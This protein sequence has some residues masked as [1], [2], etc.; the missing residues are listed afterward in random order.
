MG[1]FISL[2]AELLHRYR[3]KTAAYDRQEALRAS[4]TRYQQLFDMITEG[5]SLE[6][7][8]FDEGGKPYD[9]RYL[10]VNPAF[11]RHTGLKAADLI[12]RTTRELFPEAE[13]MWLEFYGKVASTGEPAT[14]EAWFGSLGRCFQVS[15]FQAEP[16]VCGV[17]FFDITD[18]KIA[19]KLL[20][21]ARQEAE[22]RA[23]DAEEGKRTLDAIG[24]S[25]PDAIFVKDLEG[26]M[27]YANAGLFRAVGRTADQVLGR[28]DTEWFLNPEE[29][30]A[31]MAND[32]QVMKSR[33]TQVIEEIVTGDQ[34]IHIWLSTKSP[35]LNS[36]G[37]VSG[38]VGVARDITDRRRME[39]G[40]KEEAKRKDEFLALLG[41]ELRNPLVPITNAVYLIRKTGQD[42]ALMDNV[43]AIIEHQVAHI[44]RLVDDLLDVSRITQGKI[45][46]KN[47]VVDLVPVIR[48]VT[49]DYQS[50]FAENNLT[51][52]VSLPSGPIL[53]YADKARLVQGVQ[54][55]PQR[56]QVHRSRGPGQSRL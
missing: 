51:L 45:Q 34:G 36:A 50:V 39:E 15:A 54:P 41:H 19:E 40:L 11:E 43:C 30:K 21:E 2:G 3:N 8:L 1:V 47:E 44:T 18:R 4:E 25:T 7:I 33:Q 55:P 12:G 52:E 24:N 20:E 48:G 53:V 37:E 5:F 46:L 17:I 49:R 6:E 14:M 10:A 32:R 22:Q 56:H 16:G 27:C 42:P 29:G 31:V 28:L 26:R 9:L 23:R 13:P 38:L 35:L